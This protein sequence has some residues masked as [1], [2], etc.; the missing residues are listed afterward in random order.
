MRQADY[1]EYKL[2]YVDGH[3]AWFTNNFEK[4]WRR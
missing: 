3:K 1:D 4:Q 2:C